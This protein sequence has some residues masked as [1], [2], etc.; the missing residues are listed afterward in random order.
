[1]CV[2]AGLGVSFYICYDYRLAKTM[3]F[4]LKY[5]IKPSYIIIGIVIVVAICLIA[6]LGMHHERVD[7]APRPVATLPMPLPQKP[8]NEERLDSSSGTSFHD[9]VKGNSSG[10][11]QLDMRPRVDLSQVQDSEESMQ[12]RPAA[13]DYASPSPFTFEPHPEQ[14]SAGTGYAAPAN[15]HANEAYARYD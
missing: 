7:R 14:A 8:V 4:K 3:A 1:M 15:E 2:S 13:V 11:S 10:E 9:I 6:W 12:E 5:K